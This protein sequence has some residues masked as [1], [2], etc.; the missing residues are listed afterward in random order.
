MVQKVLWNTIEKNCQEV[1]ES[2]HL[3]KEGEEFSLTDDQDKALEYLNGA[4]EAGAKRLLL[5]A[6]T[7]S[8]KTEVMMRLGVSQYI[9]TRKPVLI[10]APTRDLG[11]QTAEYLDMRL[12]GTP[13]EKIAIING[14]LDPRKRNAALSGALQGKV[15]F[16]VASAMIIDSPR[17]AGLFDSASILIVDDVNAFKEDEH[18]RHLKKHKGLILYM[19]ATPEA[20]KF[21]LKKDGAWDNQVEMEQMPFDTKPTMILKREVGNYHPLMQISMA[22][23]K[24]K[25]HIDKGSRI[26]VISRLK[27][28][29][30]NIA[31]FIKEQFSVPVY[32]LHGDM[33]DSKE[34]QKRSRRRPGAIKTGDHRIT[35]MNDFKSACPA[36]MVATNLIGSGIDIPMADFIIITDSHTFCDSEKE[37]LIGRVGRRERESE[38]LLLEGDSPEREKALKNMVKFSTRPS[39]NGKVRYSFSLHSARRRR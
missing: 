7:G 29:V 25:E 26:Y 30:A 6:P 4:V 20:V 35:M 2:Q 9:K 34:H 28:E 24:I 1:A 32:S 19:S 11:R 23:D 22:A 12:K 14:G 37:Q 38:A 31:D 15:A 3:V 33:A 17:Y 36:I 13:L 21:F 16:V 8:G 18:L 10:L 39:G 5:K 27:R